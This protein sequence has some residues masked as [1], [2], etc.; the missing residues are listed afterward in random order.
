VEKEYQFGKNIGILGGGQ[1]GKMICLEAARL[2]LRVHILDMEDTYPAAH[3]CT[4]FTKGNFSNYDD[5][6]SFGKEMDIITIEIE[7]VNVKALMD[8][9]KM[10]KVVYP[11]P[12]ALEIIQ[13][14]GKQKDFYIKH[15]IAT[16]TYKHFN[17]KSSILAA[18]ENGQQEFPFVQKAC[19]DGYDG[20]GV[21]VI[22]SKSDL[23]NLMDTAS[24]VE[25]LVDIEKEIAVIV[26]RNA[27]GDMSTYPVVEMEFHPTANLVEYLFCP[28]N[29]NATIEASAA[30]LAKEVML[31][32]DLIGI[33]AVEMFLT[34]SGNIL[35][36]EVAPRPHNSGHHTYDAAHT[37]QFEQHLRSIL[38]LPLGDTSNISAS[39]MVN[40]LGEENFTGRVF[41]DGLDDA[42]N[43]P[44]ANI[45]LYGK[46]ETRPNRKMGHATLLSKNVDEAK[47]NAKKLKDILKIKSI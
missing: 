7:K 23:E 38:N 16:S 46:T 9:E 3:L 41:Y 18:V 21:V 28:A 2:D 8:L 1:L 45:M 15:H 42:I 31:S 44:G 32:F 40:L 34:K 35:I 10:G 5:V 36:N 4:S 24:I 47:K 17:G 12:A 30:E 22:R 6:M 13:D 27:N 20:K 29:I 33:L 37:S 25:E 43:V 19:Q 14:K 26:A 39:V 11:Q